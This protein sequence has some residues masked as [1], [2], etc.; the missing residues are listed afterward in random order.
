[1]FC[2]LSKENDRADSRKEEPKARD[3]NIHVSTISQPKVYIVYIDSE[4]K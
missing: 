4:E 1:M 2:Y 3:Y